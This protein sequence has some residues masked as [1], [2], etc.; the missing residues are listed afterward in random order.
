VLVI[1]GE[2]AA[3]V[4]TARM[5]ARV[6]GIKLAAAADGPASIL[7]AS[8][9]PALSRVPTSIL[10]D[11]SATSLILAL[12]AA[13]R[14]TLGGSGTAWDAGL[15]IDQARGEPPAVGLLAAAARLGDSATAGVLLNPSAEAWDGA[16]SRVVSS[17]EFARA[18]ASRRHAALLRAVGDGTG[19]EP[20]AAVQLCSLDGAFVSL[21]RGGLEAALAVVAPRGD[22]WAQM[23]AAPGSLRKRRRAIRSIA[24]L[25]GE[26][27]GLSML[28]L[29]AVA[30]PDAVI[31]ASALR[32]TGTPGV[33]GDKG[34][35]AGISADGTAVI[36]GSLLADCRAA[37]AAACSLFVIA[38]R[39]AEASSGLEKAFGAG[40]GKRSGGSAGGAAAVAEGDEGDTRRGALAG[41]LR[42]ERQVAQAAARCAG[43][44][45]WALPLA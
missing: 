20:G 24:T 2:G 22:A 1:G 33:A 23:A 39:G 27:A 9:L 6:G 26:L 18:F 31:A 42:G 35:V 45:A 19:A 38:M 3:D 21:C 37:A 36:A 11:R 15:A 30:R 17:L 10:A 41:L 12:A 4:E 34:A 8:L 5:D 7:A 14:A 16:A 32:P 44:L 13:D 40:V 25:C 28:Q 29:A 43:A